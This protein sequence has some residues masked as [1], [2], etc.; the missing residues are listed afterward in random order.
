MLTISLIQVTDA[1]PEQIDWLLELLASPTVLSNQTLKD[2]LI[3]IA[4]NLALAS[5]SCMDALINHFKPALD[6]NQYDMM[7]QPQETTTKL[8]I[9][10]AMTRAIQVSQSG[11][12][13]KDKMLAAGVVREAAEYLGMHHPPLYKTTIDSPEWKEFLA[14]PSL[15]YVLRLLAGLAHGHSPSQMAI[16][17]AD[18]IP[19]VHRL[20]QISTEE[21]LGSLAENVLEALRENAEVANKVCFFFLLFIVPYVLLCDSIFNSQTN[22]MR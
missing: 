4:P 19:I 13:L 15:K 20:E 22:S 5:Q 12:L 2:H 9:F 11:G 16:A 10:C 17:A 18:C 3:E 7:T 14:K 21:R 8:D 1:T 6:F